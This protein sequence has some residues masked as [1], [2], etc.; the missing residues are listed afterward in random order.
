LP[1]TRLTAAV[2]SSRKE[3]SAMIRS[4][5]LAGIVASGAFLLALGYAGGARAE[6][7]V[8]VK[9]LLGSMGLIE[10]SRPPITY[11][12]RAPL[13]IPPKTDLRPPVDR[14]AET[15]NAQWPNDPDIAAAKQ[16]AAVDRMPATQSET[17]RMADRNARLT[18]EELRAGTKAGA[19]IPD[20]PVV[21]HGDNS[22]DGYWVNPNVLRSQSKVVEEAAVGP[23]GE[24]E[25]RS[26]VEPPTGYRRSANN[27][28]IKNDAEPV[29][30]ESDNEQASPMS[31]FNRKLFGE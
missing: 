15:A 9:D 11:R 29:I 26:L 25:R 28:K 21:R 10:K 4:A 3:N 16:K 22:R 30:R 14:R 12:E 8:V 2:L 19:G 18:P 20:A 7:G 5:G 6:E 1:E 17:R 31:F 13:V 23:G 24:P 27:E